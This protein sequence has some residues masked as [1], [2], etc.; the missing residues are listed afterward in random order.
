MSK[1]CGTFHP[2]WRKRQ[3][4]PEMLKSV[5]KPNYNNFHF[6]EIMTFKTW[7]HAFFNSIRTN[8]QLLVVY[9][10]LCHF[11]GFS[12]YIIWTCYS[13]S[14]AHSPTLM[15]LHLHHSSFFNPSFASPTLQSLHLIHLASCPSFR[16]AIFRLE[17]LNLKRNIVLGNKDSCCWVLQHFLT[18]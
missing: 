16:Q 11:S 9:C 1:I 3:W 8:H 5:V 18:S 17:S 10:I 12:A 13:H 15:L 6:P 2:Q 14:K 4:W 7:N